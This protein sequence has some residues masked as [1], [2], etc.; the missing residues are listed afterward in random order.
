MPPRL[1]LMRGGGGGGRG[2]ASEVAV[3]FRAF[4]TGAGC[5]VRGPER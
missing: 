3:S 5:V 1:V 2:V 4:L